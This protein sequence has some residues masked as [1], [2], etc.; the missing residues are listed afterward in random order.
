MGNDAG[1]YLIFLL[2]GRLFALSL[3]Q[4]A[5]IREPGELSPLPTAPSCYRGVTSCQGVI[6]AVMDLASFMGMPPDHRPEKLVVL[7]PDVASLAFLVQRVLRIVPADPD[8]IQVRQMADG[9]FV[10][11]TLDLP[12]GKAR[13]LDAETIA[14]EATARINAPQQPAGTS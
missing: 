1:R 13:L 6:T 3:D 8:R 5:E 11:R 4:V 7:H 10:S 2:G 9:P 14:D 12:E